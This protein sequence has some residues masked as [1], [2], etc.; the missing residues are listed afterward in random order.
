MRSVGRALHLPDV[1]REVLVEVRE[2]QVVGS[3][4]SLGLVRRKEVIVELFEALE[5]VLNEPSERTALGNKV[6]VNEC[7]SCFLVL[8]L[9]SPS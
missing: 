1:V 9:A 7:S 6:A 5:E 4:A 3:A 8:R 2:G